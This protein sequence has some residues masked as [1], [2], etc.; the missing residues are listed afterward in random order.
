[1]NAPGA[2]PEMLWKQGEAIV[3]LGTM[4]AGTG[5]SRRVAYDLNGNSDDTYFFLFH[6]G[7]L[8]FDWSVYDPG[9]D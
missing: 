1:M 5:I 2:E 3:E 9:C 4:G 8:I 6:A 7:D